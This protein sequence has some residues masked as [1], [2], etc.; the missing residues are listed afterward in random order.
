MSEQ[1]P[2]QVEAFHVQL[3][4]IP[5][6]VRVDSSI[7]GI[8]DITAEQLGAPDLAQL[9]HALIRRGAAA[10][11]AL[12][13]IEFEVEETTTGWRALEFLAWAAKDLARGGEQIQLRPV[14]LPPIANGRVQLGRTLQFELELVVALPEDALPA[15]EKYEQLSKQLALY[16]QL[17]DRALFGG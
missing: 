10:D 7:T 11:D 4:R 17:Y 8:G 12:I 15:L 5:G 1:Y 2:P 13:Q 3:R 14:A 6:I 16:I 9:P